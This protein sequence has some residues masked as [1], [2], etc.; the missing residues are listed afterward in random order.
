MFVQVVSPNLVLRI[1]SV[2]GQLTLSSCVKL[3][4]QSLSHRQPRQCPQS[5]SPPKLLLMPSL[6]IPRLSFTEMSFVTVATKSLMV[7]GANAWIVLT[8]IYAHPVSSQVPQRGTTRS[9]NSSTLKH[10]DHCSFTRSLVEVGNVM[11]PKV[12]VMLQQIVLRR[13]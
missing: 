12:V 6:I 7:S 13:P 1:R 5:P 10:P 2:L 3:H 9:M 11:L 4:H 8:M